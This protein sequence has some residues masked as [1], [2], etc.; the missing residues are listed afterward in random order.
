MQSAA[1]A[2][3]ARRP[4][5]AADV[6]TPS[7]TPPADHAQDPALVSQLQARFDALALEE[8]QGQDEPAPGE[9]NDL[10]S[11]GWVGVGLERHPSLIILDGDLQTM[12]WES[13]PSMKALRYVMLALTTVCGHRLWPLPV[14][15]AC[16]LGHG[17]AT[18]SDLQ[19]VLQERPVTQLVTD[20]TKQALR[21]TS[22]AFVDT[23]LS[24]EHFALDMSRVE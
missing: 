7:P 8:G 1:T 16:C 22:Q 20:T 11:E 24:L 3:P 18:H 9:Q 21:D 23:M 4:P 10:E 13:L 15:I 12:P 17:I 14:G 2:A 5:A 19:E 6:L